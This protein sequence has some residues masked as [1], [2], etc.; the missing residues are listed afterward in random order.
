LGVLGALRLGPLGL[1]P[2]ALVTF[3]ALGELFGGVVLILYR[4]GRP[5]SLGYW[6]EVSIC[7]GRA[8]GYM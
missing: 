4:S 1:E 7:T 8:P 5:C 2:W 3:T 6:Q